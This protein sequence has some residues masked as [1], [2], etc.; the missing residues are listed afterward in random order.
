[1]KKLSILILLTII[2]LSSCDQIASFFA[3]LSANRTE[4]SIEDEF[5]FTVDTN[6]TIIGWYVDDQPIPYSSRSAVSESFT[7]EPGNHTITVET[8]NVDPVSIEVYVYEPQIVFNVT[9]EEWSGFVSVSYDHP[10][11]KYEMVE[12][13]LYEAD[14]SIVNGLVTVGNNGSII[15]VDVKIKAWSWAVNAMAGIKATGLSE[16]EFIAYLDT[17]YSIE[18][19]I[20]SW[21]ST[22]FY[23][24]GITSTSPDSFSVDDY[25]VL[26]S[27][28]RT[29]FENM[30]YTVANDVRTL[31]IEIKV[32][33]SDATI[34]TGNNLINIFGMDYSN[35]TLEELK[36]V[37]EILRRY[38]EEGL[39]DLAA[40]FNP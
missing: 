4:G 18:E 6:D 9:L 8:E 11:L 30:P 37:A 34:F 1:M 13:N 16:S 10:I 12:E 20:E 2:T 29:E 15:Y 36:D 31:N 14:G 17:L 22:A 3:T 35:L 27:G 38:P 28:I 24:R 21:T 40:E 23:L 26:I 25:S 19:P 5:T 39:W 32:D 33:T 7:F